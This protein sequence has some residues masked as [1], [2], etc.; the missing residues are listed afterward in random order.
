[1]RK[2]HKTLAAQVF[3]AMALF[4]QTITLAYA[5]PG[6]GQTVDNYCLSYNGTTPFA[7]S[8][9]S[10]LF[11]HDASSKRIRIDPQWT[12]WQNQ[13]NGG[14]A[15]FCTGTVNQAPDG[16]INSPANNASFQIGSQVTFSG[17]GTDPENTPLT[18]LWD[19]G[20]AVANST[21]AT[22]D[23]VLNTAGMFTVTF[24]VTD[25]GG[26][27]DPTPATITITVVDPNANKAP[28]GTIL[29]PA[30]DVAINVGE[31][32][33][34]TGSA[35]DPDN[36]SMTYFWNFGGG[37]EN[38]TQLNPGAVTFNIP[39]IFTVTFSVT[40]IHGLKDPT[41]DTRVV[42]VNSGGTACTDHDNDKYSPDGGAC[43]P[44]DCNDYDA[45]VNP[46]AIEACNDRI[47]N[48]CNGYIDHKDPQ[49]NGKSCLA[50]LLQQVQIDA[51]YW[52]QHERELKVEGTWSKPGALVELSD[53]LTGESLA[54]TRI[55]GGDVNEDHEHGSS[56]KTYH[57]EFE[58]EHLAVVPCRV[59]VTIDNRYGERDVAYAPADCSG[60]PPVSNREPVAND[61]NAT[62]MA[63]E[64][65]KIPVLANDTDP[66]EDKLTIV[67]FTQPKHGMVTK[68]DHYLV[69][70]PKGGYSGQDE[71][72]YTISDGHGGTDS[73]TVHVAVKKAKKEK[74]ERKHSRDD[75]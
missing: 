7:E 3:L 53:A 6:Y 65:V 66:D 30:S 33:K 74:R 63:K 72:A 45:A 4:S 59:R 25:A 44:I 58:L 19:F 51:A 5:Q 2:F 50:E 1:M 60:K 52:D 48:D 75:D 67:M 10:C 11:C 68:D 14:L 13:L 16:T 12:W 73:A 26:R 38:S 20:G 22:T 31:S 69:Y 29:E 41:P 8:G 32:V 70:T 15:N 37:A 39:G 64:S 62:T 71:F 21:A 35:S 61:D 34:F 43:G 57:W 40:D 28:N 27:Q 54:T 17:T 55:R 23:V 18:Y 46:G 56:D 36:D 47:D 24:T 9:S 49:C 42:N